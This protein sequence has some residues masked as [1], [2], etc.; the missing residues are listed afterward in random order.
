MLVSFLKGLRLQGLI[1]IGVSA[2][3]GYLIL[4]SL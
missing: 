4:G 2:N 3:E 1:Y